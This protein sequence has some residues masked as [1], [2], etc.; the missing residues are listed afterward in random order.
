MKKIKK[1]NKNLTIREIQDWEKSFLEKKG[2]FEDKDKEKAIKT[3]IC[4]LAEETGEVAE[5]ILEDKWDKIQEEVTDVIVF[6]CK[7]ANIAEKFY[8]AE[9]LSDAIRKKIKICDEREWNPDN[10]K[11]NKTKNERA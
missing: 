9:D 10:K 11:L 3:A 2:V 8:G 6:A 1:N 4:K 7:V 5:A